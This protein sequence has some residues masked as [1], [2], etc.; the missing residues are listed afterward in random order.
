MT[1]L[2]SCFDITPISQSDST[3]KKG[4]QVIIV[5]QQYKYRCTSLEIRSSF[6]QCCQQWQGTENKVV[7]WWVNRRELTRGS[8]SWPSFV[9]FSVVAFGLLIL[10]LL[11]YVRKG[12]F[13]L[14]NIEQIM[15]SKTCAANN[16]W[17]IQS[18]QLLQGCT[19]TEARDFIWL[20]ML[21]T[22]L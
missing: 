16:L 6:L 18:K 8:Y 14:L 22:S 1:I 7:G 4:T 5:I 9:I 19:V 10:V 15:C 12:M 20:R 17:I 11:L 13:A 3:E 21:K 2:P